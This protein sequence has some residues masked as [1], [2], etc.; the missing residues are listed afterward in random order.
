MRIAHL[1]ISHRHL[2]VRIFMKE[3]RTAAAAGHDVHVLAPGP[4]PEPQDGVQFHE[5][6]EGIGRTTAYFWRVLHHY[7]AILRSA[8]A[9]Q[10][11]VYQ[12]CDPILIPLALVLKRRGARIVY[13]VHEERRLQ[14]ITK[15]RAAGRP[16]VGLLSS[17]LWWALEVAGRR[18]IDQFVG[19]TPAIAAQLPPARTVI[20]CNF[21][22][23]D[24]FPRSD[25]QPYGERP[26]T[27]VY[28][29]GMN[30]YRG[31]KEAVEAMGL[32]PQE[33][34]ARL[35]LLGTFSRANPGFREE[36]EALDG[37]ARVD[38][39]EHVPREEMAPLV[40]GARV[41]LSPL[42]PRR[43]HLVA[44]G[45]KMFEY[46][47]AGIPQVCSDFPLLREIVDEAG[48]GVGAD[49]TDPVAIAAAIRRLLEHPG[50]AEA[51]GRRAREAVEDRYNWESQAP[52]LL[53]LYEALGERESPAPVPLP[54]SG[55]RP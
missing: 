18:R 41:G 15:Y 5:L 44:L 33:L 43:E 23:L 25:A 31:I 13:D 54:L 9:V 10:A 21:P 32:L 46:M 4:A 48:L 37:W 49:S 14:A 34:D 51:M 26:N 22:L 17:L 2:D 27:V 52:A 3:A 19:A 7:P 35:I 40:A 42:Q 1:T 11:D 55:L 50:E 24:E 29:G 8:R 36:L 38:Y 20:L 28:S 6:P 47:A 39:R 53:E 12:V 16:I 45:N 30:K